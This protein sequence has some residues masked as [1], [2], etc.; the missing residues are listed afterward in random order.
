V[1]SRESGVDFIQSTTF[2]IENSSLFHY[3]LQPKKERKK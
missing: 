3:R 2:G 1:D